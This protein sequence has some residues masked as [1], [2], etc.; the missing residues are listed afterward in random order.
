[1]SRRFERGYV[2]TPGRKFHPFHGLEGVV[3][4]LFFGSK[5]VTPGRT[6]SF[7]EKLRV[8][9]G[10]LVTWEKPQDLCICETA[11]AKSRWVA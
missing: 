8:K 7:L 2:V 6:V 11:G 10:C 3:D 1:M 5:E 9:W 4:E